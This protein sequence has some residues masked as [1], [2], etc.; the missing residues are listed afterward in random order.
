M[1]AEEDLPDELAG[2]ARNS[3]TLSDADWRAG[4]ARLADA[5]ERLF[6]PAVEAERARR[7]SSPPPRRS[8]PWWWRFARRSRHAPRPSKPARSLSAAE[9]AEKRATGRA[10]P[11]GDFDAA[12]SPGHDCTVFAPASVVPGDT[13]FVQVFAPLLEQAEEAR[14]RAEELNSAAEPRAFRTL[15]AVVR[16]GTRLTFDLDFRRLTVIDPVQSLVWNGRPASVQFSVEASKDAR[17]GAYVGTVAVSL[18]SVPIGRVKFKLDVISPEKLRV[19]YSEPVGDDARRYKTAFVSYSSKDRQAVL[20]RVQMLKPLGID[21]FQD[22]LDLDP[23]D[24]WE[25]KLYLGIDRCDLFLLWSSHAKAS[26]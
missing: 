18:E 8:R 5:L 16:R 17:P 9:L 11:A 4:E 3:L 25:R 24:R 23:G 1:P 7:K 6:L 10:E 21:F 20:E 22:L 19:E 14:S 2:L 15:E 12:G 13:A 26:R